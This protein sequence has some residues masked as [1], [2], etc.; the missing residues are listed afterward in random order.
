MLVEQQV[1]YEGLF[2]WL[3]GSKPKA[4]QNQN[5]QGQQ[6]NAQQIAHQSDTMKKILLIGGG[7]LLAYFLLQ[8][9]KAEKKVKTA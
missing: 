8:G 4:A 9:G 5:K 1:A 2:D 6:Q 3:F 7:L